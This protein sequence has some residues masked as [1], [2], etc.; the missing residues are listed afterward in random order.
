MVQDFVHPQYSACFLS[1]PKGR[2]PSKLQI[3]HPNNGVK[4][5][6]VSLT[7][8]ELP[9][10]STYSLYL[11]NLLQFIQTDSGTKGCSLLVFVAVDAHTHTP[12]AKHASHN[13]EW[14]P[15][16]DMMFSP[17][18]EIIVLLSRHKNLREPWE[19]PK[20]SPK[21]GCPHWGKG[22]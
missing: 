2:T 21:K 22:H 16:A 13:R 15:L 3:T 7:L 11:R 12:G 4:L 18:S 19:T 9:Q 6:R 20:R 10:T 8:P 14:N 5:A 1:E 17:R